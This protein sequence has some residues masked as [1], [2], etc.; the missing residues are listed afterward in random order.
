MTDEIQ[1]EVAPTEEELNSPERLQR[2][3]GVDLSLLDE[4]ASDALLS[5]RN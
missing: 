2:L 3:Y 4:V 1:H 5:H